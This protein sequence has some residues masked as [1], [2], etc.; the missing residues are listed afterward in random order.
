MPVRL[1]ALRAGSALPLS[2]GRLLV[3]T[4]VRGWVNL[5]AIIRLK[6]AVTGA[7]WLGVK[8]QG[9]EADH[10][11]STSAEVKKTC[12]YTSTPPHIFMTETAQSMWRQTRGLHGRIR[13]PAGVR[14]F[15]FLHS[16]QTGSVVNLASNLK[17]IGSHF[18]GGKAPEV[19]WPPF[20]DKVEIGGIMLHF[21]MW[22]YSMDWAQRKL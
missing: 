18:P 19:N 7:L 12:V 22:W 9:R 15:C 5:R 11:P 4:S 16:I 17:G 13:S 2:P 21:P 6:F 14:D 10:S 3:L 8:R 20:T 1:S